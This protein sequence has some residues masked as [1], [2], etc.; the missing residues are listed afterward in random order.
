MNL[1]CWSQWKVCCRPTTRSL[2]YSSPF[3]ENQKIDLLSLHCGFV[4][5]PSNIRCGRSAHVRRFRAQSSRMQV[6]IIIISAS[7]VSKPACASNV[8][9]DPWPRP[10]AGSVTGLLEM[11]VMVRNATEHQAIIM[12]YGLAVLL[13]VVA[14]LADDLVILKQGSLRGHRLT[15]RKGREIFAFQGIPYAKP[16]VG[17]L[18]FKVCSQALCVFLRS[19]ER[20]IDSYLNT[21]CQ[22]GTSETTKIFNVKV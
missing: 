7:A 8:R 21:D 9:A 6:S 20:T 18:R 14:A 1:S 10:T 11:S 17:E 4:Q 12:R 19:M 16:P 15:S 5:Q 3:W 13:T 2:L 22:H